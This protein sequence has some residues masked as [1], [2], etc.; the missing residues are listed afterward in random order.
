MTAKQNMEA[1]KELWELMDVSTAQIQE[2]KLI[3]FSKVCNSIV[4]VS[5]LPKLFN[6]IFLTV[7]WQ[8]VVSEAQDKVNEWL[9]RANS[10]AKVI[11]S[12]DEMLQETLHKFESFSQQLSLLAKLSSPTLKHKHWEYIFKG[13][14]TQVKIIFHR[15]DKNHFYR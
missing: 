8:F 2:W 3:L 6:S 7:S 11:P 1:R 12:S 10:V 13:K 14:T 5:A 15:L 9:Q 4:T